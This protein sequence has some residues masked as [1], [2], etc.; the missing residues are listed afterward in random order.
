MRQLGK[1][2]EGNTVIN[3]QVRKLE[4]VKSSDGTPIPAVIVIVAPLGVLLPAGIA[5]KIDE[6]EP[7]GAQFDICLPAG[8]S[9]R[10]PVTEVFLAEM[11]AGKTA[12]V[13]LVAAPKKEIKVEIS[14]K[15]FTKA[16]K[17]L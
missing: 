7:R 5:I 8:C 16:Y 14:L 9:M 2:A 17:A 13:Q 12:T 15:G 6:K 1:N 10:Q 3:L 4:G 11:K